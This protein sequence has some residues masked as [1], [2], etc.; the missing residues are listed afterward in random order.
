MVGT[1]KSQKVSTYYVS[2]RHWALDI[3]DLSY[4]IQKHLRKHLLA[5]NGLGFGPR[6][7]CLQ[8]SRAIP[9]IFCRFQ[10]IL[11]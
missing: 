11:A 4:L 1:G 8:S 6:S 9:N 5:S 7:A 10:N 2:S 3:Y